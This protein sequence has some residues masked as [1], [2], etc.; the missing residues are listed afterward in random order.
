MRGWVE[1]DNGVLEPLCFLQPV[2][3]QSRVDILKTTADDL[4]KRNKV[5]ETHEDEEMGF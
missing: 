3:P 1:N 2:L 4:E 5:N